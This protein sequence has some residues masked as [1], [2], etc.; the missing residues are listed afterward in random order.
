MNFYLEDKEKVY[1]YLGIVLALIVGAMI[2]FFVVISPEIKQLKAQ[3]G[4]VKERQ[5]ELARRQETIQGN[6]RL[7]QEIKEAGTYHESYTD[8]LFFKEDIT[9]VVK[10]I[11]AISRDLELE[12]GS[13]EPV[14]SESIDD[15]YENAPFSLKQMAVVFKMRASYPKLLKF[16][17]RVEE[18]KKLFKIETFEIKKNSKNPTVH[19]IKMTFNVFNAKLRI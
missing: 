18:S 12:F 11:I 1:L 2:F 3:R 8:M 19:D 7:R 15:F 16:L 13:I 9:L 6:E 4:V 17:K 14:S 10:E 5:I